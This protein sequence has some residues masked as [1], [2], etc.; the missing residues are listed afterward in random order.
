MIPTPKK[1]TVWIASSEMTDTAVMNNGKYKSRLCGHGAR[2]W[3]DRSVKTEGP[4]VLAMR[5]TW[6]V[7]SQMLWGGKNAYKGIIKYGI[8]G[9]QKP[10]RE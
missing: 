9:T 1:L 7:G 4:E 6:K 2:P 3:E 8:A 5:E 10:W